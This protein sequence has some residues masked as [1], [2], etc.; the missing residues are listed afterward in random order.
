MTRRGLVLP[1]LLVLLLGSMVLPHLARLPGC[2]TEAAP[3]VPADAVDSV[4]E[5]AIQRW[6]TGQPQHWR[7][8]LLRP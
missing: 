3:R 5:Q 6:R 8:C 7:A 4:N 1:G 2:P